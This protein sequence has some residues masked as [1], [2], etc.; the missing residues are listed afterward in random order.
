[1]PTVTEA[2]QA[3]AIAAQELAAEA[4]LLAA[5]RSRDA[6]VELALGDFYGAPAEPVWLVYPRSERARVGATKVI[7]ICP[8]TGRVIGTFG[9]GE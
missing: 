4:Q 2:D 9:V 5:E 1:M 7:A 3:R 6:T 8:R